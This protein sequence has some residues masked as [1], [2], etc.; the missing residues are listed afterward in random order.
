VLEGHTAEVSSA[1]ELTDGR[2]LSWSWDHTLRLWD[3]HTYRQLAAFYGDAPITCCTLL[4]DREIIAAG[5]SDGRVLFLRYVTG[6]NV[7]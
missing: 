4:A 7:M 1:L 5:D 3:L 6:G 2:L